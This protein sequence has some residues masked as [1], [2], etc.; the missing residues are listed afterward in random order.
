MRMSL[1]PRALVVRWLRA[2]LLLW[3]G[4]FRALDRAAAVELV[5]EQRDGL[6]VSPRLVPLLDGGEV[7]LPL[8]PALAALPA[9]ALEI[10]GGGGEHVGHATNQIGMSPAVKIDGVFHLGRRQEL[11]LADF[12]GQSPFISAEAMSPRSTMRSASMSSAWNLSV[13]R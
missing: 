11:G 8:A 10:I 7:P 12:A 13:R 3:F 5:G 9:V 2:C 1:L 4:V 6:G